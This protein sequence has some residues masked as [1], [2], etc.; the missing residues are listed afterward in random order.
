MR[1]ASESLRARRGHEGSWGL[2]RLFFQA[3]QGPEGEVRT[4]S[5]WLRRE[6]DL[7]PIRTSRRVA[8]VLVSGIW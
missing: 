5:M 6:R 3:C 8:A 1:A 2:V 4:C 7:D